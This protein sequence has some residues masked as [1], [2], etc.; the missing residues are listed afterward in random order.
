MKPIIYLFMAFVC[1]GFVSAETLYINYSQPFKNIENYSFPILTYFN[2][3]VL[4]EGVGDYATL[5]QEHIDMG[6][7]LAINSPQDYS[8]LVTQN[9]FT[10]VYNCTT[11]TT[12]FTRFINITKKVFEW[13]LIPVLFYSTS[14]ACMRNSTM[15]NYGSASLN[16]STY[17]FNTTIGLNQTAAFFNNQTQI[18][19]NLCTNGTITNCPGVNSTDWIF[20]VLDEKCTSGTNRNP[21]WWCSNETIPAFRVSYVSDRIISF[22]KSLFPNARFNI[23][24]GSSTGT[25]TTTAKTIAQI[26]N[27]SMSGGGFN[28]QYYITSKI[29]GADVQEHI[30]NMTAANGY[31]TDRQ[32][33]LEY[34]ARLYS[35]RSIEPI[36][37][38]IS[39]VGDD[40]D[41]ILTSKG[42]DVLTVQQYKEVLNGTNATIIYY[43]ADGHLYNDNKDNTWSYEGANSWYYYLRDFLACVRNSTIYLVAS[44][45]M[46]KIDG[47]FAERNDGIKCGLLYN[48]QNYS[49]D[50]NISFSDASINLLSNMNTSETLSIGSG[51]FSKTFSAYEVGIYETNTNFADCLASYSFQGV[52]LVCSITGCTFIG[53]TCGEWV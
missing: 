31:F 33:G 46:S 14:P 11:N 50:V 1:L 25:V 43:W 35:N 29:G 38:T 32:R 28:A 7:Y 36:G 19:Y 44:S 20:Y 39:T 16:P 2:N 3:D 34:Y 51:V 12:D 40:Y 10:A 22:A 15:D 9:E 27:Y 13:D 17:Y 49:V 47:L 37:M 45:N 30:N 23:Y 6:G 4:F 8:Y 24:D 52:P 26:I 21:E 5:A 48:K 18:V 53:T 41:G 42:Y